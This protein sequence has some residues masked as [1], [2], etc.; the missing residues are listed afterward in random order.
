[1]LLE[2]NGKASSSKRTRHINIR[3]SFVTDSIPSGELNVNYC[4]T[5]NMIGDYFTKIL[6]GS[7]FRKSQ[8]KILGIT[9]TEIPRYIRLAK[10]AW[11]ARQTLNSERTLKLGFGTAFHL[12][13][14]TGVCWAST[15]LESQSCTDLSNIITNIEQVGPG[16]S[17]YHL[18]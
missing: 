13:E 15:H 9:E 6:Q 1:M 18:D 11:T 7:L 4:P 14:T 16:I 8:K 10:L 17:I 5:L 3:Y 2:K 12:M